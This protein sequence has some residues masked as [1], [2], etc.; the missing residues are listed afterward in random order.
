M[1]EL[2]IATGIIELIESNVADPATVTKVALTT[3]PLSGISKEALNFS[4]HEL[5]K[6]KGYT[7]ATLEIT[8]VAVLMKC[9]HC[10]KEYH[11]FVFDTF[12]PSCGKPERDILSVP[13]FKIE[14]IET[15]EP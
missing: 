15:A 13:P 12:C 8:T 1:H 7:H 4:F 9:L 3:S 14:Y 11:C 10:G 5:C 2:S 6:L